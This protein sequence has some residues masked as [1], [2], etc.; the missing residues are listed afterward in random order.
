MLDAPVTGSRDQAAPGALLVLVGGNE[1]TIEAAHPAFDTSVGA[2]VHLGP[3]SG[4]ATVKL[5][6]KFRCG[7]Q[8]PSPAFIALFKKQGLDIE[9]AMFIL[10]TAR[11]PVR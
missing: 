2:L 4:A 6:S 8:A 7:V 10:L 11:P 1:G 9:Q 3:V 5:A